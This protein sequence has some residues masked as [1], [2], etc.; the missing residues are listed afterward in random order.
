MFLN[1]LL[2]FNYHTNNE[3]LYIILTNIAYRCLR[4]FEFFFEKKGKS[5]HK[6]MNIKAVKFHNRGHLA[7]KERVIEDNFSQL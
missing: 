7:Q 3:Y 5:K 2:I 4:I 6:I 1:S